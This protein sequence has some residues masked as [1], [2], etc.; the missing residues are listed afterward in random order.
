MPPKEDLLCGCR[1]VSQAGL[2]AAG[3]GLTQWL[4]P[5]VHTNATKLNWLIHA[6]KIHAINEYSL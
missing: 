6:R 3:E 2:G 5:F 4:I 1:L